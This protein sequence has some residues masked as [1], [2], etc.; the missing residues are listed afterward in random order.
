MSVSK[1]AKISD[2]CQTG[3]G[4][5][6]SRKKATRYF[7]GEIPWVKSGELRENEIVETDETVTEEALKETSLKLV[8]SGALLVA[9]YGATVGRVGRLAIEATTNQAVCHVIPDPILADERYVFHALCA[10]ASELVAKG[11]GGAQPNISQGTIRNTE[12]YLPS[13]DEQKRIASIL[14]QAEELRRKRQRAGESLN[15]LGQAIFHEM[16]GDPATNPKGFEA[17]PLGQIIAFK[18]GSQPPKSNFLYEDGPDRVRFIQ[19]RDFRTDKYPTYV[20]R[21]LAQRPFNEDD[22][23]IGRYGPPVFQIL[24]GLSGTYN[25]ALMKAEPKLHLTTDFVFYLLQEPKLHSFVVA[26][27][28][29]TAGQSGVNLELLEKYPAYV[30]PKELLIKFSERI[31]GIEKQISAYKSSENASEKLFAALQHRAFKG[32]L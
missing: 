21:A 11:V 26:N 32:E 10:K 19:I 27:S 8:P 20:P 16:F 29:R 13:L 28:E 15:Q 7:G 23:M 25:V 24:R 1:F 2:F 14:D 3:S 17:L 22:V 12:V 30:P 4:T 9:M 5:T 6:P 31:A 18:G